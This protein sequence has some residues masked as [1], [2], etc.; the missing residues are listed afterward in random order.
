MSKKCARC[1]KSAPENSM[2]FADHFS[3]RN[4]SKRKEFPSGIFCP[5]FFLCYKKLCKIH[6]PP[7]VPLLKK[8]DRKGSR[9]RKPFGA[10]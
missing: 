9:K 7:A 2:L 8:A 1:L 4:L 3:P 5:S 10:L 6:T